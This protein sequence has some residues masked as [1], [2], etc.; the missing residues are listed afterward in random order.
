M[1]KGI[2]NKDFSHLKLVLRTGTRSL[3][4]GRLLIPLYR[5]T[6]SLKTIS[7]TFPS[8]PDLA[9]LSPIMSD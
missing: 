9:E 3:K 1:S 6:A 8:K 4:W 7:N 5:D 2:T